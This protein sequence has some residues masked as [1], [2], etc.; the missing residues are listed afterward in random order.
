MDQKTV[1]MIA[2]HYPPDE[3][4][5]AQRTKG[6]VRHLPTWG[7]NPVVLTVSKFTHRLSKVEGDLGNVKRAFA[8]DI[9]RHLSLFGRYP[10]WLAFPDHVGSWFFEGVRKGLLIIKKYNVKVIWSTFPVATAHTIGLALKRLTGLPWVADFRDP[11]SQPR[12]F[13]TPIQKTTFKWIEKIV[14]KYADVCVFTTASAKEDACKGCKLTQR[15]SVVIENGF[16]NSEILRQTFLSP[17]NN[18]KFKKIILVHSGLLYKHGRNPENF[19]LA[20]ADLRKENRLPE[21]LNVILRGGGFEE[22]YEKIIK[23]LHLE[24]IISL[25]PRTKRVQALEEMAKADGLLLFQG[26][27]FNRQVPAKIYEYFA[28]KKPILGLVDLRGETAR[29]LKRYPSAK[30]AKIDDKESIRLALLDLFEELPRLKQM[31]RT[32]NTAPFS[33]KARAKELALLLNRIVEE[34]RNLM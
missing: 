30:L 26:Q 34:D 23:K 21:G 12:K 16:E 7:W 15:K 13:H 32:F 33:R 20:I 14:W 8:L 25:R 5:G 4:S 6:F 31:V 28:M 10:G 29:L 17:K 18:T 1:L 22:Y 27:P 24:Q 19:F 11:M 2:Y 3:S 9:T